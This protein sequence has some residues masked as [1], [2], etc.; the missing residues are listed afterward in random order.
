MAERDGIPTK[1]VM[2]GVKEQ[3][4]GEFR[5]KGK[6]MGIRVYPTEPY[7]PWQNVAE[8]AIHEIKHGVGRKMMRTKSPTSLWDHCLELEGFVFSHTA[9]DNFEL[10]GEVPEKVLSGQTA[11]I[12]PFVQHAWYDWVM[13]WDSV[14]EFPEPKEALG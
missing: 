3:V 9:L 1:I 11:D 12:S 5:K 13:Y 2:D 4:M 6:E 10:K 8:G 14:T 7:S